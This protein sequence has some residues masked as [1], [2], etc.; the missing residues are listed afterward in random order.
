MRD[1][2]DADLYTDVSV[3]THPHEYFAYLRGKG[4]ITPLPRPNAMA[5]TGYDE[6]LQIMLD[7]E[8]FSNANATGGPL[9]K[10]FRNLHLEF[11]PA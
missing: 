10:A 2:A 3:V 4:L 7:T 11:D 1:Y 8:H 9:I 6:A 5:V